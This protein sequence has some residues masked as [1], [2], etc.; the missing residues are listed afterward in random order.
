VASI[1]INSTFYAHQ[2]ASS[3]ADWGA[4]T[5]E[6]FV[7]PVKGHQAVTH[8]RRLKE[9]EV[10][11]A[12]F[13]A[14]GVLALGKR[15]G[16]F[17]WQLPGNMKY[18]RGRLERFLELLPTTPEALLALAARHDERIV[19]PY[20]EAAGIERVRHALEVRHKSFAEPEVVEM[21]RAANVAL[22]VPDTV[23]WPTLDQ[24]AD[25]VYCRL[26]GAPGKDRY[27]EGDLDQWARRLSLWAAGKPMEEG[28]FIGPPEPAMRPKDVF[29][30]FVSTDKKNAPRNAMALAEKLG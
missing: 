2:K 22:V 18:D 11:L 14:S 23:E 27:E 8:I 26:Q 16:P 4:Q 13:F 9:V 29:C 7:F 3:F 28:E 19:T 21:L 6:Y 10:P 1:E 17:V 5:P 12:N 24:T 20:L 30:H 15:L 25:F